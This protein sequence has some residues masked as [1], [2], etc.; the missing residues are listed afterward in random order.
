MKIIAAIFYTLS[1][2][3]LLGEETLKF[4]SREE[5]QEMVT[6]AEE[7]KDQ[8]MF[9][10]K[11]VENLRFS[12]PPLLG[13]SEVSSVEDLVPF[14]KFICENFDSKIVPLLVQKACDSKCE[15]F[16]KRL[17]YCVE[18]IT[19]IPIEKYVK[20]KMKIDI[21]SDSYKRIFDY[22][23]SK[24]RLKFSV[25]KNGKK[26]SLEF[27]LPSLLVYQTKYLP[28]TSNSKASTATAEEFWTGKSARQKDE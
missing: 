7:N 28:N 15:F 2:T 21:P 4:F 11:S 9:L 6:K 17:V 25:E 14:T 27:Y 10:F 18:K 12:L 22:S 1:F 13:R 26:S 16:S 5:L 8:T 23:S 24:V 19:G 3:P 20:D